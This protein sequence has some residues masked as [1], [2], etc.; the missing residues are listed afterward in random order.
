VAGPLPKWRSVNYLTKNSKQ[1]IME[2]AKLLDNTE[3]QLNET[4]NH[5]NEKWEI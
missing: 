4:G 1:I 2:L 3:K 5:A